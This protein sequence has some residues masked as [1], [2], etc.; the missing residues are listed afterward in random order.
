MSLKHEL[1]LENIKAWP[2]IRAIA[3]KAIAKDKHYK[4]LYEI[5]EAKQ[6]GHSAAIKIMLDNKE[7][8]DQCLAYVN[9]P[10]AYSTCMK[11]VIEVPRRF[12]DVEIPTR[13]AD[14]MVDH[15]GDDRES[16]VFFY[17]DEGVEL[18]I[19]DN[20][21]KISRL[22]VDHFTDTLLYHDGDGW[23]EYKYEEKHKDFLASK[24]ALAFKN[25]LADKQLLGDD[26]EK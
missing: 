9:T 23:T 18:D 2:E 5:Q 19:E 13:E 8:A 4:A 15:S 12:K 14:F 24:I 6:I 3:F 20:D 10:E 22:L 1:T 16:K 21:F 17:I 7:F 25:Y 11:A 26:D